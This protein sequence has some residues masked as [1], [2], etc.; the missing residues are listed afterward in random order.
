MSRSDGYTL[1]ELLVALALLGVVASAL[2][3]TFFSLARGRERVAERVAPMRDLRSTLDL[4]RRELAAARTSQANKRLHF[5]VEDRDS[6]GKPA[7][8]LDFTI[9]T[10][11]SAGDIPSSDVA[12]VRYEVEEK[13]GK[14]RLKRQERDVYLEGATPVYEQMED[15]EGFLVECYNGN[16]WVK[17]WNTPA[18]NTDLPKGVRVTITV[19]EQG[20]ERNYSA[21]VVPRTAPK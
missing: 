8:V 18:L 7:S 6:F 10:L 5:V 2:Y 4:L 13:G 12:A 3:G 9:V 20:T 15:I 11:P 14:L 1:I 19:R 17:S 16:S 21:I